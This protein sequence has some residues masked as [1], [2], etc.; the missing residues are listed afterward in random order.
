MKSGN[1]TIVFAAVLIALAAIAVPYFSTVGFVTASPYDFA[2]AGLDMPVFVKA[3][4]E[5]TFTATLEN[6][7]KTSATAVTYS[8]EVLNPSGNRVY[9]NEGVTDLLANSKITIP[10]KI[11]ELD[12]GTHTFRINIDPANS[13]A[14]SDETNNGWDFQFA[15]PYGI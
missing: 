7:G 8:Y 13:F 9:Y 14:E 10:M 15:V 2:V 11:D 3:G 5:S 4:L 6:L 1:K 12:D